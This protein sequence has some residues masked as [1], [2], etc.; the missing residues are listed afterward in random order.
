MSHKRK[1]AV[2]YRSREYAHVM[3]DPCLGYIWASSKQEAEQM[4]DLTGMGGTVGAWCVLVPQEKNR[5]E[6]QMLG[7]SLSG[8]KTDSPGENTKHLVRSRLVTE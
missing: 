3:G 7:G 2:Y 8:L 6:S 1:W 5:P 4:A